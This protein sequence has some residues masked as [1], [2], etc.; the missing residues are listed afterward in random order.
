MCCI[1]VLQTQNNLDSQF[2][3]PCI[4]DGQ[5]CGM[6][7][8]PSVRLGCHHYHWREEKKKLDLGNQ[9][10]LFLHAVTQKLGCSGK[11]GRGKQQHPVW[12]AYVLSEVCQKDLEL[13]L[14]TAQQLQEQL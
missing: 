13:V 1:F 8:M 3:N 5:V 9:A 12:A 4:K 2:L 6:R 10:S 11:E 7:W 14:L